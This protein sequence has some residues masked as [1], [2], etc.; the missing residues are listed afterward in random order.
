MIALGYTWLSPRSDYGSQVDQSII[1][2]GV[3]KGKS[4]QLAYYLLHAGW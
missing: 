4:M 3:G 2:R 1:P